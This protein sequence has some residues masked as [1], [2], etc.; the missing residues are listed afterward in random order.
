MAPQSTP[1][2]RELDRSD[3]Q[4]ILARNYIGRLAYAHENRVGIQPVAYVYSE[5]WI[6][7]RTSPGEKLEAVEASWAPVAF[8]VDEVESLF[9]WR[10]V[11]V[12]GGL[13]VI[14]RED[15]PEEWERAVRLLRTLV[16]ETLT[17]DDPVPHRSVVF[18]IAAAEAT[19]RAMA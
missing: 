10:S 1:R 9:R 15:E 18:R 5:G 7:G 4:S 13:Y 16:Q 11:V 2:V 8:Q 17:D 12:R 19:G 14:S 6:Y 3:I